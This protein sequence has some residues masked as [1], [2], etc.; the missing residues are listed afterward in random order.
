[1]LQCSLELSSTRMS[2]TNAEM[3]RTVRDRIV[4][5]AGIEVMQHRQE[6]VFDFNGQNDR[7]APQPYV[8]LRRM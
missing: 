6:L 5:M 4:T 1:M 8:N 2:E 7:R 3:T